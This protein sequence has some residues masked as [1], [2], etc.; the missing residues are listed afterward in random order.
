MSPDIQRHVDF[1]RRALDYVL[2]Y[3]GDDGIEADDRIML[4]LAHDG[5]DGLIAEVER[6]S[7]GS[8]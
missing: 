8:G 4:A 7:A 1:I 2:V 6:L 5:L 3:C